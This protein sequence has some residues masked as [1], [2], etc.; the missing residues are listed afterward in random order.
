MKEGLLI[1][2]KLL[3]DIASEIQNVYLNGS[4]LFTLL[5]EQASLTVKRETRRELALLK[6]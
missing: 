6:N 3:V 4:L 2:C 5:L 1:M